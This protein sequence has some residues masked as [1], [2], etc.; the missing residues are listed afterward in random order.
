MTLSF[1]LTEFHCVWNKG[2]EEVTDGGQSCGSHSALFRVRLCLFPRLCEPS[3]NRKKKGISGIRC[4]QSL[5]TSLIA[6]PS[7]GDGFNLSFLDLGGIAAML[8]LQHGNLTLVEDLGSHVHTH[9]LFKEDQAGACVA[10][11]QRGQGAPP[12]GR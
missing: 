11:W 4:L 1:V 2:D 10:H 5:S 7:R 8:M 3:T 6:A 12:G 9:R